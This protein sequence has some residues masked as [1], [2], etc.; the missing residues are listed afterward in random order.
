MSE[1]PG[2]LFNFIYVLCEYKSVRISD[3]II[4]RAAA[5]ELFLKGPQGFPRCSQE[6]LGQKRFQCWS[7]HGP[8]G[9]AVG[10]WVLSGL[11]I[12]HPGGK[13]YSGTSG[14]GELWL[15]A[16]EAHGWQ[17]GSKAGPRCGVS[18]HCLHL[19]NGAS[20]GRTGR[21]AGPELSGRLL[22]EFCRQSSALDFGWREHNGV[23][24]YCIMRSYTWNL[25]SVIKWCYHN[26]FNEKQ[27]NKTF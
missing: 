4:S 3:T 26:T 27:V 2:E 9:E 15:S 25:Y 8:P 24:R 12:W 14:S 16:F 23:Y 10:R 1:S 7:S 22:L 20:G 5:S 21:E 13:M 18:N 11:C 19:G 6:S 17:A